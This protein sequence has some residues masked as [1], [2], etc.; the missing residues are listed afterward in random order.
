MS[1]PDEGHA[2]LMLSGFLKQKNDI[3]S[4]GVYERMMR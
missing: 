3:E 4:Y 2:Q 1:G